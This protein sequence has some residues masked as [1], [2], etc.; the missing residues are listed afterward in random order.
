MELKQHV[1]ATVSPQ[2]YYAKRFPKWTPINRANQICPWHKE[3]REFKPS[4]SVNLQNGG[5]RCHA[6]SKRLG[7]IVHFESEALGISE[8]EAATKLYTEFVRP[9]VPDSVVAGLQKA[10]ARDSKIRKILATECGITDEGIELF[11]LGWDATTRRL[12][13]PIFDRFDQVVNLRLYR[14]P[15]FRSKADEAFKVLNYVSGR[16]TPEEIRYGANDLF[17]WPH[18]AEFTLDQPVFVM[19]SEKEMVIGMQEGLQTVCATAGEQSWEESWNEYFVGYDICVVAQRDKVGRQAAQKKF[20]ALQTVANYATIIEPPTKLKDFADFVVEEGGQGLH[21]LAAFNKA[22]KA[23]D[24]RGAEAQVGSGKASAKRKVVDPFFAK[25]PGHKS[26]PSET[27]PALPNVY[28]DTPV[29][30]VDVGHNPDMLNQIVKTTGIVAA[31]STRTYSIPWKFKVKKQ[32]LPQQFFSVPM[33]RTLLAFIHSSDGQ[34]KNLV[35]ELLEDEKAQIEVDSYITAAEVEVIPTAAINEDV[36]YVTQRCFF[37]G[38]RI[39]ANIPYE[40]EIIPT[41]ASQ[42]QETIGLIIKATPIARAVETATFSADELAALQIFRPTGKQT[43][44][45]RMMEG[46]EELSKHY[47]KIFNRPDW[48]LVALLTWLSPIGWMF[49]YEEEIQRG[50]LNSLVVGD[51]QT[52]KS[53]VTQTFQRLFRSGAIINAENCTYVGL[54]GGA[55]KMGSGQFMLRW[56]RIPLSDK[57]LVV[58]EELSGLSVEEISNMSDV[59]SSG[60]ARLDKGGLSAETNA[61]TR[62]LALSNVRPVNRN[63][64]GYLSGVKA[65]QELI[66]HGED[67]ARFDLISTLVDREVS[68]EVIN[69]PID[70]RGEHEA[71]SPEIYQRLCQFIWALRPEQIKITTDAYLA[72]LEETK[73]LSEIYHP[74]VPVFK[75]GSGR[76]KLARVAASIACLQFSWNGKAILVLED[77]V[78]AASQFLELLYNKAS[79][80]YDEWSRQMFDRDR[81]KD[82]DALDRKLK[83]VL[84]NARTRSKVMESLVHAA[85][86]NRD[87]LCAVAGL[88]ISAADMFIGVMVRERVLRKGDANLWE[89]TP[90]GRDWMLTHLNDEPIEGLKNGKNGHSNGKRHDWFNNV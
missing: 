49:P 2:V 63:L 58:I 11:A 46:A 12:A 77:H 28:S 80:G 43:V 87:E 73:R 5:A 19:P 88:Q 17:S 45:D 32:K 61:R 53:K 23:S 22:R 31:K 79:F 86:F 38:Q 71:T 16:N 33:G 27:S 6:C 47:T 76:Y 85:K 34:I 42:S 4:L 15:R 52:G 26:L 48:H 78:I 67:I 83:E 24:G 90:A 66:G 51:T 35:R 44:F 75:G 84:R 55:V 50:W 37:L 74:A 39:E 60:I 36:P 18:F 62:L 69:R 89:I 14:P 29:K 54:V 41:T 57:Q 82:T 64:A 65:I 7:N 8:A 21:L 20:A 30:L 3:G 70:R 40:L 68:N 81:V 9:I 10:L 56:G 1:I 59:R 72:C 25:R 13:I